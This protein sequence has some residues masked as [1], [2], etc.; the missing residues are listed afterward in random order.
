MKYSNRLQTI[1]YYYSIIEG[2]W[3]TTALTATHSWTVSTPIDLIITYKIAKFGQKVPPSP[4]STLPSLKL[5]SGI[6]LIRRWIQ[7]TLLLIH[8]T[9]AIAVWS[10]KRHSHSQPKVSTSRINLK[11]VNILKQPKKTMIFHFKPLSDKT[12]VRRHKPC[13]PLPTRLNSEKKA[14][15]SE[16]VVT[17]N[18]SPNGKILRDLNLLILIRPEAKN[19]S[20][21][22]KQ[23]N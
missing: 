16:L 23:K 8:I 5:I 14:S 9:S 20:N 1:F 2:L 18:Y 6:P 15:L 4:T 21:I 11:K 22:R 7:L 3:I 10:I 13:L 19:H 17:I 12:F